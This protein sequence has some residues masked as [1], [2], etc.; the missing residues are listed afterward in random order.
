M[1]NKKSFFW[2]RVA[3]PIGIGILATACFS[4]I[5][6]LIVGSWFEDT[7]IPNQVFAVLSGILGGVVSQIY[8]MVKN[9]TQFWPYFIAYVLTIAFG[10]C[11]GLC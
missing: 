4:I 10:I 2:S 3:A 9:Q 5:I 6:D 11:L 8:F 1:K 7:E